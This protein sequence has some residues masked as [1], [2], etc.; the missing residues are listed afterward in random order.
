MKSATLNPIEAGLSGLVGLSATLALLLMIDVFTALHSAND[1]SDQT[2]V[3]DLTEWQPQVDSRVPLPV[4]KQ[5][6]PEFKKIPKTIPKEINSELAEKTRVEKSP[7]PTLKPDT[8][9]HANNEP[10]E[11]PDDAALP[12]PVPLFK[13]T[14]TPR[15]LHQQTPEYPETLRSLGKT[16]HVTLSVLIDKFGR[17]RN[18]TVLESDADAFSEAAI[19]AIMASSFIPAKIDGEPVAVKL[20]LPVTFRLL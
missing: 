8:P 5:Q 17:V 1:N 20:K 12:V 7:L 9:A 13:L 18:I 4:E 11:T 15:F 19:K 14:E 3:I 10:V 16:G 2:I 6:Q